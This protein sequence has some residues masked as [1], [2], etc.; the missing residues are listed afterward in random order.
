MALVERLMH[1]DPDESRD[2]GVHAFFAAAVEINAGEITVTQL[3]NHLNTTVEDDVDL[4]ALI[5]MLTGL[6]IA[7]RQ[8]LLNRWH[9][10]FILAETNDSDP[11]PGYDTP[12]NVRTKLGI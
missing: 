10:V 2:M 3:K 7:D 6:S 9:S 4:D 5:A 8:V 11:V 1:L 12:A